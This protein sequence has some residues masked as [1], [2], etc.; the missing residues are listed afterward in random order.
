MNEY[1]SVSSMLALLVCNYFQ[2][3][4]IGKTLLELRAVDVAGSGSARQALCFL[5]PAACQP[6]AAAE[7]VGVGRIIECE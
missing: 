7:G 1:V 2:K 4:E 6:G 5:H 3:V